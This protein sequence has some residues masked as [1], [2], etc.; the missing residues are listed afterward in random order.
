MIGHSLTGD[1]RPLRSEDFWLCE[2]CG[3]WTHKNDVR[4][5]RD[6]YVCEE[7]ETNERDDE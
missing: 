2:G 1:Q 6:K 3:E 4:L 5:V 7:C